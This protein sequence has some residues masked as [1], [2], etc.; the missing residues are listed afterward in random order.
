MET[1]TYIQFTNLS[2]TEFSSRSLNVQISVVK[3]WMR[4][5]DSPSENS[6]HFFPPHPYEWI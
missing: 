1:C 6:F 4:F 5:L 3:I 2:S